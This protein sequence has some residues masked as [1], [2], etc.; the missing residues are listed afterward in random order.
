M[1][2]N[3]YLEAASPHLGREIGINELRERLEFGKPGRDGKRA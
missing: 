2:R 1:E 3:H